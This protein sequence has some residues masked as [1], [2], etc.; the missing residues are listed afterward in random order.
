MDFDNQSSQVFSKKFIIYSSIF[1]AVVGL[2]LYLS[3][4][5][6]ENELKDM[7]IDQQPV[8][9]SVISVKPNDV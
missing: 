1:I 6:H 2:L 3:G 9:D 8:I 4:S 5:F 7:Q